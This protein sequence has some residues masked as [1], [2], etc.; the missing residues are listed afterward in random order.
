M[1]ITTRAKWGARSVPAGAYSHVPNPHTCVVHHTADQFTSLD[2]K[3]PGPRWWL[4]R[5]RQNRRVQAAIK[6]YQRAKA[7]TIAREKAAMRG[8]QAYH[9]DA[10]GWTDLGY[11]YVIFPSGRVYEGRPYGTRGAHCIN[12]NQWAG[13]SFAG[14]YETQ[15]PTADALAAYQELRQHRGLSAHIGHYRVV[16]NATA[17][18]GKHLKTA[19]NL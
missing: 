6:A 14:N 7:D 19:L 16:G 18:P 5:W 13:V 2:G 17:C 3:R 10:N 12:G 11:H 8:M 15:R 9:M 1:D 4:P